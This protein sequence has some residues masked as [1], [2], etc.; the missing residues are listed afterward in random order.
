MHPKKVLP[1][2]PTSFVIYVFRE[3]TRSPIA[4]KQ[5]RMRWMRT[6]VCP[7]LD[8]ALLRAELIRVEPGVRRVQVFEQHKDHDGNAVAGRIVR[9]FNH[10]RL[11]LFSSI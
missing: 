11:S 4:G 10:P 8:T 2:S 7:D 9:T 1:D 3:L 6:A 5:K